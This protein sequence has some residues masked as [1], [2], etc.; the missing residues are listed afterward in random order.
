MILFDVKM[1]IINYFHFNSLKRNN[2]G[3]WRLKGI[4]FD[5]HEA[6]K[7]NLLFESAPEK[8]LPRRLTRNRM[9]IMS[10][11]SQTGLEKKAAEMLAS[12]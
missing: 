7:L 10:M 5:S 1:K 2:D 3:F 6:V 11:R 4:V 9:K 8:D 12:W